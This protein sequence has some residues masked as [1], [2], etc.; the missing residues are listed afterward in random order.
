[1]NLVV[2]FYF[3]FKKIFF[4]RLKLNT[5]NTSFVKTEKNI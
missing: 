2:F 1:M 5:T 4:I 3:K